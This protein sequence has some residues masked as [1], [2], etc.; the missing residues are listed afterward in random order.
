[1]TEDRITD[2]KNEWLIGRVRK[3]DWQKEQM[4]NNKKNWN[5]NFEI[6]DWLILENSNK[7][8]AEFEKAE[9]HK[10]TNVW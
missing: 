5:V 10:T 2:K 4:F 6:V 7:W 9:W 1:M 3:A 8:E